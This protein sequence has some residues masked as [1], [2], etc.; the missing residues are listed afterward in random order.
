MV[1]LSATGSRTPFLTK[2]MNVCVWMRAEESSLTVDGKAS[3]VPSCV[4]N[5]ESQKPE[6]T[7]GSERA[8][9][10]H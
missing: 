7:L 8:L 1:P 10:Y 9:H 3:V 5:I 6:A 2:T 4:N